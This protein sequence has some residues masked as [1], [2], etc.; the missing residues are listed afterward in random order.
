MKPWSLISVE[1]L[2][3]FGVGF[4]SDELGQWRS[5]AEYFCLLLGQEEED[6]TQRY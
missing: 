4:F 2:C 6:K 1:K 3:V 5:D